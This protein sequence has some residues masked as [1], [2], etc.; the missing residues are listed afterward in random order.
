MS[1]RFCMT[2]L[3]K[4]VLE[5]YRKI[6]ARVV[7]DYSLVGPQLQFFTGP[8]TSGTDPFEL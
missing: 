3:G 5:N 6:K 2:S 1:L 4:I 7:L 8:L